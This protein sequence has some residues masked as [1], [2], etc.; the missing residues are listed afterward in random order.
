MGYVQLGYKPSKRD[1]VCEFSL[2]PAN[3]Y[4]AR[5]AAEHVASESS[6][7][8]WTDVATMKPSIMRIAA[9]VFEIKGRWVKIAYPADLF[10]PGNMPQI[11]SSIAG[12]IFGMK[13][14]G[15]LRLESIHWPRKLM[16]SFK[17][18]LHGIPGVRRMLRVSKRPLTGTIVKP[19]V[20]LDEHEHAMVAYDAWSG[21]LDIV[22]DDENLSSMGFNR[23]EERVVETLKLRDK[24]ERE[25][26]DRKMYMPNVT[27]E[28]RE[29]LKRARFVRDHGGEYIMVDIV[30]AGWSG[31]QT[32][33]DENEDLKLVLHAHRAGHAAFTRNP[34]HGI[35]MLVVAECS[36]LI[37]VDQ[38][39]IGTV[40]GKM[41]GSKHD[42]IDIG[43]EIEHRVIKEHGHV[44]S[45]DWRGIKPVFAVCSGGLH[46]GH[47]P[48]LVEILGPD[49][50]CQFGGGCHGH[51][52]GTRSGAMAIRQA[53]DAA[54]LGIDL[55]EHAKDNDELRLALKKWR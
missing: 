43:E 9:K 17:G 22:K 36:R 26:G 16:E 47:V 33:R 15:N 7:G 39:H 5:Q 45:D 42:V 48:K 24:A 3:G 32:L 21:G 40:V 12:N 20:G 8:T 50:I 4:T 19:K 27:A 49:I 25:T 29:M 10:E 1:M 38:I 54:M 30:T 37:G 13:M 55:K 14:V 28:C 41:H 35:S 34:M 53:V 18:P 6:V 2:E 46:P 52:K 11:L 31:L 44:L 23:F 51:P